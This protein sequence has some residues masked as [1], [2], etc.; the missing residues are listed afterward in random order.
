MSELEA[1]DYVRDVR[2]RIVDDIAA[3]LEDLEGKVARCMSGPIEIPRQ[4]SPMSDAWAEL[5]NGLG[6]YVSTF[7][8]R[9]D[10][11][12]VRSRRGRA[13]AFGPSVGVL[14][15]TLDAYLERCDPG[16]PNVNDALR[17]FVADL[18]AIREL[19]GQRGAIMRDG[20]DDPSLLAGDVLELAALTGPF[21][22]A[23]SFVLEVESDLIAETIGAPDVDYWQWAETV[24]DDVVT[25]T[26]ERRTIVD[27][28]PVG[29][30]EIADRLGVKRRTVDQWLQRNLMPEPRW[31]IGGRPAW[32]WA[33][34]ELWAMSTNRLES[35]AEG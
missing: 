24:P 28:Q 6:S 9:G 4:G 30:K 15:D 29:I 12:F 18:V 35:G 8:I 33:D 32:D 3:R 19:R 26:P 14:V 20:A 34:V 16:S 22:E 23:V 7:T 13:G 10:R 11:L 1:V 25:F 31:T 27:V 17:D 21:E 5:R 2:R